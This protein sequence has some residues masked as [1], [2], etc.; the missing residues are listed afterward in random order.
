MAMGVALFLV[1]NKLSTGGFSGISTIFYHLFNVPVGTTMLMLNVPLFIIS[2]FKLGKEIFTKAVVGTLFLSFFLNLFEKVE[3][4]TS[5]RLLACIYGGILIGI[6][7]A[8]ILKANASTGG[9]DLLAYLIKK[10]KPD[11]KNGTI[12][13][14]ADAIVVTL[15]VLVFKEIEIALYSAIAIFIMG[16]TIDIF[17]EGIYFS[18]IVYIVS[19]KYKEIASEIA[20]KVQRGT[21]GLYAKGM[22]TNEEKM[23]L[24]CVVGR[25]EVTKIQKIVKEADD[26]AFLIIS[27]AREVF[28][29]GFK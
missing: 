13:V 23:L 27:N 2:F 26:K 5:D 7:T 16:K 1:P 17:L 25:N 19:D 3:L 18:K 8:F 20:S 6:G 14:I 22:Y 15:N 4:L 28:G 11:I 9:S 10:Q 12:I 24:I 21:T 29:K